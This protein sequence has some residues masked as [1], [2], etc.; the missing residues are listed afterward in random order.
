MTR[1]A[2]FSGHAHSDTVADKPTASTPLA[3]EFP[4]QPSGIL[5]FL[6]AL[7]VAINGVVVAFA[8]DWL[9]ADMRSNMSPRSQRLMRADY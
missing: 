6:R 3:D 7:P 2:A 1:T 9:T 5:S 8:G 4:R